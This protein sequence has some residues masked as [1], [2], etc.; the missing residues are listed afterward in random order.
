MGGDCST[1]GGQE[2]YMEKF[3]RRHLSER[4]NLEYLNFKTKTVKTI[5]L[6]VYAW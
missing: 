6:E 5:G 4:H 2:R 3:W 1:Y